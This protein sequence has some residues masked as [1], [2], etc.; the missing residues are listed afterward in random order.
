MEMDQG[1]HG[2][3]NR[4]PGGFRGN[5]VVD[6]EHQ[7]HA[8]LGLRDKGPHK[9]GPEEERRAQARTWRVKIH[10]S[11]DQKSKGPRRRGPGG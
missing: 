3:Q 5:D 9:N 4:G 2:P 6:Q 10:A 7:I 11:T 1:I 8:S